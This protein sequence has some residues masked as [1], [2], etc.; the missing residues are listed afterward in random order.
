MVKKSK[1]SINQISET[2]YAELAYEEIYKKAFN[3]AR[4]I[5]K[6]DSDISGKPSQKFPDIKQEKEPQVGHSE[7]VENRYNKWENLK[8]LVYSSIITNMH[9]SDEICCEIGCSELSTM[10]CCSC[11]KKRTFC[12]E[13]GKIHFIELNHSLRVKSTSKLFQIHQAP[14]CVYITKDGW[15]FGDLKTPEELLEMGFF[16][17]TPVKPKVAF[18]FSFL[19][20]V[21]LLFSNLQQS[22]DKITEL[23]NSYFVES[24]PSFAFDHLSEVTLLFSTFRGAI[25]RKVFDFQRYKEV[26]FGKTECPCCNV[27]ELYTGTLIFVKS[28]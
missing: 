11:T 24:A 21:A 17:A 23:F 3:D 18:D 27:N 5:F 14:S 9:I 13:H 28:I 6:M 15:W 8:E 12:L 2:K 26:G 10:I 25:E 1:K 19:R 20:M 16:P 7:T 4:K 22:F